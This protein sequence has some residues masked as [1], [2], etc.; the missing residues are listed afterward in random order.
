M[1]L[2]SQSNMK[3]PCQMPD[4]RRKIQM[5]FLLS[6]SCLCFVISLH[7]SKQSREWLALEDFP[8]RVI[9]TN[10]TNIKPTECL[11]LKCV[12]NL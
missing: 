8:A 1:G 6:L 10:S 4:F 3:T 12:T 9:I 7:R 2:A 5:L 11:V